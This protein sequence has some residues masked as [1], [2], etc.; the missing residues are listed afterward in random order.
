MQAKKNFISLDQRFSN[1]APQRLARCAPLAFRKFTIPVFL[2]Y[3]LFSGICKIGYDDHFEVVRYRTLQLLQPYS[4]H[5]TL[6][7]SCCST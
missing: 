5:K 4:W 2:R 3:S 1:G 6:F 7:L